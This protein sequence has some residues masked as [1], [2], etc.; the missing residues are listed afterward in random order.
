MVLTGLDMR[1]TSR[2][3]DDKTPSKRV[4][5]SE[6]AVISVHRL[7]PVTPRGAIEWNVAL[8]VLQ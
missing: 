1:S 6:T 2:A 5:T 3:G 4:G 8:L 7:A